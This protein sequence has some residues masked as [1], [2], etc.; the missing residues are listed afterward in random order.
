M[1]VEDYWAASLVGLVA[2]FS[3]V[4]P[5]GKWMPASSL[6]NISGIKGS[7]VVAPSEEHFSPTGSSTHRT[8]WVDVLSHCLIRD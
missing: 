6:L 1:V 2:C 3:C 7:K 5:R 4:H 8:Q